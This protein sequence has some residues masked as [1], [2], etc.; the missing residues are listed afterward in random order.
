[1]GVGFRLIGFAAVFD[2]KSSDTNNQSF[3]ELE[4]R[5][6]AATA[7]KIFLALAT[8]NK[9]I[10]DYEPID[11]EAAWLIPVKGTTAADLEA[12]IAQTLQVGK[13][14]VSSLKDGKVLIEPRETRPIQIEPPGCVFHVTDRKNRRAIRERGLELSN[15]GNTPHAAEIPASHLS[16]IGHDCG[17]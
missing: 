16:F 2:E 5:T 14:I 12:A 11:R 1:M 15:G 10:D 13:W 4:K 3:L 17:V 6:I 7:S 9:L 8:H